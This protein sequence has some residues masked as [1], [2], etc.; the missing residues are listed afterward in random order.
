MNTMGMIEV[1]G[2]PL[3]ALVRAAYNPSRPQGMGHLHYQPG[4][5]TEAEV[6]AIV[7]RGKNSVSRMPISMDYVKGRSCKFNVWEHGGRL[8]IN[9][10]WYD[11]S[12]E[13]LRNLLQAV[14]LS[15]D[16]VNKAKAERAE[17]EDRCLAAALTFLE[18]NDGEWWD[19][20][21][22]T[23]KGMEDIGVGF[24]VGSDRKVISMEWKSGVEG[25][26][27]LWRAIKR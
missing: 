15:P 14:G 26:G 18:K 7:E 8:W 19:K 3:E 25:S 24:Y 4:D 6:A 27:P 2:V 16:L 13:D 12:S 23:K 22:E 11:H 21:V 10:N 5:L 17:Y 1:T 9:S 20:D